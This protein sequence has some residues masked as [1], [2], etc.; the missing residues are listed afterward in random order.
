MKVFVGGSRRV[1]RLDAKVCGRLETIVSKGLSV[2]VGDANGADKAVQK[3][4]FEK[5]YASVVVY[6]SNATCRNNLGG[7]TLRCVPVARATKGANFYAVKDRAMAHDAEVGFM[8]WD[9]E[10]VGTLMNIFRLL[11]EGK[12]AV[13]FRADQ[14][15]F[16]D[17]RMMHEWDRFIETCSR[18]TQSR[19]LQRQQSE[20]SGMPEDLR[21]LFS[22]A[23]A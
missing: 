17:F 5:G 7:W 8:I 21:S 9:G 3:F 12:K 11:K 1:T 15:A 23:Q 4:L 19:L 14:H 16:L 22:L 6:C 10:S 13:L 20:G 18:A 2:V